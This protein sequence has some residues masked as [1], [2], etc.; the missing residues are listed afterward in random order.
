MIKM[1]GHPPSGAQ[2]ILNGH[3]FVA[4][5]AQPAG[6]GFVEEGNCFTGITDPDGLAQ[7]A[8]TLPQDAATGRLGQ[9]CD[10]RICSACLRSGLDLAE[11]QASGFRCQYPAC[12]AEYSRDLIFASGARMGRV[13]GTVADRTRSRLDVPALRTLFG[14]EKRPAGTAGPSL[15]PAAVI[16]RPAYDLTLFKVHSGLLT[17]KGYTE[18]ERVLRFEA[19][20]HST[21]TLK[22]GRSLGKFPDIVTRLAGMAGRFCTMLDCVDTGYIPGGKRPPRSGSATPATRRTYIQAA[23]WTALREPQPGSSPT[24]ATRRSARPRKTSCSLAGPP[25]DAVPGSGRASS[26]SCWPCSQAWHLSRSWPTVRARPLPGS[27]ISP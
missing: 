25:G 21:R 15:K 14:A 8:E 13:F 23:G 26:L 18:G 27:V 24:F 20:V 12:Q 5:A 11:Q 4:A 2:V 19:I 22:T 6:I 3:E 7:I 9:V 10:R 16:E 17:L 1:S